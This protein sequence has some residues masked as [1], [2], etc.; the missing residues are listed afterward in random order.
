MG[1]PVFPPGNF[2]IWPLTRTGAITFDTLVLIIA[3]ILWF[4]SRRIYRRERLLATCQH[5]TDGVVSQYKLWG[6]WVCGVDSIRIADGQVTLNRLRGNCCC[7]L[8]DITFPVS[9][10]VDLQLKRK[11]VF[12]LG[13]IWAFLISCLCGMWL[14]FIPCIWWSCDWGYYDG[15]GVRGGIWFITWPVLFFV[16][17]LLYAVLELEVSVQDGSRRTKYRLAVA[18]G[19]GRRVSNLAACHQLET[20]RQLAEMRSDKPIS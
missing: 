2:T 1:D 17:L 20:L 14:H 9:S 3:L 18:D 5:L 15:Q 10:L 13:I 11:G 16:Y 8:Q 4:V 12:P 7:S 19:S 6:F